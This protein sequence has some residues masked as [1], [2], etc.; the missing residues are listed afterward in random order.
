[1][2]KNYEKPCLE[3]KE[4]E[5]EITI[6]NIFSQIDSFGNENDEVYDWFNIYS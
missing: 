2:K 3:S 1:M 5:V 4:F 6:A